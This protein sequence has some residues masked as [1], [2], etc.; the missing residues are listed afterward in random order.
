MTYD[1]TLLLKHVHTHTEGISV[2]AFALR[3]LYLSILSLWEIDLPYCSDVTQSSI[4]PKQQTMIESKWLHQSVADGGFS[5]IINA[6][7][8]LV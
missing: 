8:A 1:H 7:L 2:Y 6:V 4:K 5:S 3:D